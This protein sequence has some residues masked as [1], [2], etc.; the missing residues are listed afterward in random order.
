MRWAEFAGP[1]RHVTSI[2][3]D[4]FI[5]WIAEETERG[6]INKKSIKKATI[7]RGLNTIRA[8][9]NHAV[10]STAKFPDL[11]NYHVPKNPL[12]K[13]VEEE[14][15][16]VL[17]DEEIGQIC[18]ALST[19][20]EWQEALFFFQLDLITGA[21]MAELIRM[22]WEESS[23]RFGT[24]KL[25]SSKTRKWRTIKAPAAA[26]LLANRKAAGLGGAQVVLTHPDHWYRKAFNSA[27][28]SST[29]WP[30]ILSIVRSK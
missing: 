6:R 20:P 25:Y 27:T 30:E 10:E 9:L 16:R 23:L 2:T 8:D 5:F 12:T 26:T 21:R 4:D 29:T 7:K 3:K 28:L 22:R 18:D 17:S 1:L 19:R 15:D 11:S 14:R 13:K 24:V